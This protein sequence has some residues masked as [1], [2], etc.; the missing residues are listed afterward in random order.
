MQFNRK[1]KP[2]LIQDIQEEGDMIAT[3][4]PGFKGEG[5]WNFMLSLL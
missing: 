3:L 5:C 1:M 4:S 2:N